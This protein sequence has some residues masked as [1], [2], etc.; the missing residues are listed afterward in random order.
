MAVFVVTLGDIEEIK[1]FGL[2]LY[3]NFLMSIFDMVNVN[4]KMEAIVS[5]DKNLKGKSSNKKSAKYKS[6]CLLVCHISF[7][8]RNHHRRVR[9]AEQLIEKKKKNLKNSILRKKKKG[10]KKR[11]K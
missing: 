3:I 5:V 8:E 2:V 10:R 4:F 7:R 11:Q 9:G 6:R 1:N